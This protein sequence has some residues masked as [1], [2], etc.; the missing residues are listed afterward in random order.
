VSP[1]ALAGTYQNAF[2]GDMDVV[3]HESGLAVDFGNGT[4]DVFLPVANGI[5]AKEDE[6]MAVVF[7][8]DRA[9]G[10]L[11]MELYLDNWWSATGWRNEQ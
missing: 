2:I 11:T 4:A 3:A 8:P 7:R 1:E 5:Y 6:D 9:S 10:K